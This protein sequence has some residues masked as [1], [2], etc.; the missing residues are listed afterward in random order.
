MLFYHSLLL[1]SMTVMPCHD[2]T[3]KR[4]RKFSGDPASESMK[5]RHSQARICRKNVWSGPVPRWMKF[6]QHIEFA[7][8]TTG[9]NFIAPGRGDIM[10][11]RVRICPFKLLANTKSRIFGVG[12]GTFWCS[13]GEIPSRATLWIYHWCSGSARVF[14]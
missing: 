12:E 5:Y 10:E 7:H 2:I 6:R 11:F 13:E 9:R 3:R 8:F 1:Y 4:K 14:R